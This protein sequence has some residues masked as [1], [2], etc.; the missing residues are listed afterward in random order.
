MRF[1]ESVR[2]ALRA[3]RGNALRSLLT[4]LGIIIGVAAVITMVAIG[5]GAQVRV[6]EQIRSLGANLLMVVPGA[7]REGGARLKAGTRH[8]LTEADAAAIA[9]DIPLVE[10]A[11]PAVRE[12]LQIVAANRNWNTVVNG[13]QPAY[14]I[15]REWPL[16]S[17]RRF[18]IE[19]VASA[20]KVALIGATVAEALFE[21]AE[22]VG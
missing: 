16:S 14:F 6:T 10:V 21:E 15:T 11:A 12:Y 9:R 2:V 5:Q 4:M 22:P 1:W 18:T 13:T 8:T 7:A 20:A 17:G 3:L 19:E